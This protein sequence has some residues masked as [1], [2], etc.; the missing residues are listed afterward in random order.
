[1]PVNARESVLQGVRLF[2]K[3]ATSLADGKVIVAGTKA[4]RPAMP[5]LTVDVWLESRSVGSDELLTDLGGAGGSARSKVRGHRRATASISAFGSEAADY[6]ELVRMAAEDPA[7][8]AVTTTSTYS[9]SIAR[10]LTPRGVLS[11]R[12][13]DHE[14][15]AVLDL[16]VAY[17][18]ETIP[19]A[20][21]EAEHVK[22]DVI[23]D[24]PNPPADL[25]FSIIK[26]V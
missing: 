14:L 21:L 8:R 15:S 9:V 18:L 10:V 5:Y 26:D 16:E 6:L 11:L 23:L 25:T 22:M 13:T 3:A 17:R 4:L 19:A 2:V 20:I 12:D 1:M 24:R 7:K